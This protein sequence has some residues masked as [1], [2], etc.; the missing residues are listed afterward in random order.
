[1]HTYLHDVLEKLSRLSFERQS[2]K[3]EQW[4]AQCSSINQVQ[5]DHAFG[6]SSVQAN[7]N[8]L[9]QISSTTSSSVRDTS[10][11]LFLCMLLHYRQLHQHASY[12]RPLRLIVHT[13]L[14]H[15]HHHHLACHTSS[16]YVYPLFC[17]DSGDSS[18]ASDPDLAISVSKVED[19]SCDALWARTPR[20]SQWQ[21]HATGI[22]DAVCHETYDLDSRRCVFDPVLG[23]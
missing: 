4:H 17:T 3:S 11:R 5:Q 12:H 10:L 23:A 2:I 14:P 15:R 1:M 8:P 16:P 21:H 13:S 7:S 9:R 18:A 20:R 6:V 19:F 22:A